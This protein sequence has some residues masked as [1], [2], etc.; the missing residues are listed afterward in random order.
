MYIFIPLLNVILS[1]FK[2]LFIP[3]NKSSG[4]FA[5]HAFPGTPSYTTT[6]FLIY[7]YLLIC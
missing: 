1:I 7:R 4:A 3:V 2:N 5:T 6:L